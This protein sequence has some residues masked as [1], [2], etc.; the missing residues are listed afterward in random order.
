MSIHFEVVDLGIDYPDYFQGFGCCH[1]EFSRSAV[2]TGDTPR[3]A[4]DNALEDVA[5]Q[6]TTV[7]VDQ[8]EHDIVVRYPGFADETQP[9]ALATV[10]AEY[11]SEII[12]DSP[13]YDEFAESYDGNRYIGIRWNEPAAAPVDTSSE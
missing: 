4:L 1:T 7:D 2:G 11:H 6:D 5:Q 12:A 8:L 9:S 10:L 3:E 13:E